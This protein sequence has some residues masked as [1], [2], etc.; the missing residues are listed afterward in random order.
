MMGHRAINMGID[1]DALSRV[2]K[3]RYNWNPGVRKWCKAQHNRL[4]RRATIRRLKE[5]LEMDP[6]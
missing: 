3:R 4:I 1:P 5:F 2:S 6:G